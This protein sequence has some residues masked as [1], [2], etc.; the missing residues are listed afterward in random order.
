MPTPTHTPPNHASPHQVLQLADRLSAEGCEQA[1]IQA[2]TTAGSADT[3]SNASSH[4]NNNNNSSSPTA[5]SA[6]ASGSSSDDG[7][8]DN[9]DGAE[10]PQL[11][12][13]WDTVCAL[14]ALPPARAGNPA[15]APLLAAAAEALHNRL[16]DLDAAWQGADAAE[17]L[18]ALP[19]AALLRLLTDERTRAASENTVFY[20]AARWRESRRGTQVAT[21]PE[22][23]EEDAA[24][25]AAIRAP[26]LS[27]LYA[28]GVVARAGWVAAHVPPADLHFASVFALA[29]DNVRA[30][31][32]E[33]ADLPT[34]RH[35]S[36]RLPPRPASAVCQLELE[37][38]LELSDLE[39]LYLAA[40]AQPDGGCVEELAPAAAAFQGLEW[41]LELS[42]AKSAEGVTFG[43]YLKASAPAAGGGGGGGGGGGEEGLVAGAGPR[44]ADAAQAG[45]VAAATAA[46]ALVSMEGGGR[47][48]DF[49]L[50]TFTSGVYWGYPDLFG[51]GSL[52]EWDRGA[53]AEQVGEGG[54]VSVAAVIKDVN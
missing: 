24:L 26:H 33:S 45:P 29:P 48:K 17:Q 40:A 51:L 41:R 6:Y 36:W 9:N 52:Q 46:T 35:A 1:A 11:E 3:T 34:G 44:A 39:R 30:A 19:F 20:T 49:R 32:A 54:R 37:W 47:H 28:A 23:D 31:L 4:R 16:G 5:G 50:F 38:S 18:L 53:W 12:L 27:S 10:P 8:S 15:Y 22:D 25:A 21:T 7:S 13:A 42:A 14:Y 2:L 43:A